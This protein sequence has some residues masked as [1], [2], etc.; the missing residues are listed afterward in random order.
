MCTE[1]SSLSLVVILENVDELEPLRYTPT[2]I[3]AGKYYRL[4][5]WVATHL[6][7]QDNLCPSPN[8]VM[9]IEKDAD[10]EHL[11]L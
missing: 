6:S 2:Y 8:L 3:Q 9:G 1:P 4:S 11:C 10:A 5:V 7:T